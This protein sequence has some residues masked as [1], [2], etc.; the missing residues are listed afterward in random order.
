MK[1]HKK[2]SG[3]FAASPTHPGGHRQVVGRGA[4]QQIGAGTHARRGGTGRDW[5]KKWGD[6][7]LGKWPTGWWLVANG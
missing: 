6:V 2:T 7:P 5:E 4:Q 1:I 3:V